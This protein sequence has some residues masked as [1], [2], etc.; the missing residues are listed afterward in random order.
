MPSSPEVKPWKM[1]RIYEGKSAESS[2]HIRRIMTR[3]EL[4]FVLSNAS[5]FPYLYE[6]TLTVTWSCQRRVWCH[7]GG[8]AEQRVSMVTVWSSL[9]SH[10]REFPFDSLTAWRKGKRTRVSQTGLHREDKV[11]LA[12][13]VTYWH[14]SWSPSPECSNLQMWPCQKWT[15]MHPH[16]ASVHLW[17]Y[18]PT[19]EAA[20]LGNSSIEHVFFIMSIFY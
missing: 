9:A 18:S 11:G 8:V 10:W 7:I 12:V 5:T 4:H 17:K 15:R 19:M 20:G 6:G 13:T 2:N 3:L 1:W 16:N 14:I